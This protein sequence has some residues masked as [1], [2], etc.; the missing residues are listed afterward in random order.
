M[1]RRRKPITPVWV[2][3]AIGTQQSADRFRRELPCGDLG[4]GYGETSSSHWLS[5]SNGPAN[6]MNTHTPSA[7]LPNGTA[8]RRSSPNSAAAIPASTQTAGMTR[9]PDLAG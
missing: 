1:S 8:V 2:S 6:V 4:D 5:S 9:R 3:A 7:V